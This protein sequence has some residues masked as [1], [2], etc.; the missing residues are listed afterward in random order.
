[1]LGHGAGIGYMGSGP[2]VGPIDYFSLVTGP[3]VSATLL[4]NNTFTAA[5]TDHIKLLFIH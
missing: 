1:M 5:S 4:R 2:R 3:D